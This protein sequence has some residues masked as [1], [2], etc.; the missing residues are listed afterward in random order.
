[1]V[2][3]FSW[4]L[5][6]RQ[7]CSRGRYTQVDCPIIHDA[8]PYQRRP[9]GVFVASRMPCRRTYVAATTADPAAIN[10]VYDVAVGQRSSLNEL[11]E[12]LRLTLASRFS[13]L[14]VFMPL[15]RATPAAESFS[16]ACKINGRAKESR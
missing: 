3:S 2:Y 11:F 10:Q 14:A 7:S 1:M 13:R 16:E 5:R 8:G 4:T 9:A 6:P 15:Y 12:R